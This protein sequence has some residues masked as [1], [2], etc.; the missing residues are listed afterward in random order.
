MDNA[1][2]ITFESEILI[3]F[4]F[5]VLIIP[6]SWIFAWLVAL[7]VHEFSHCIALS[8]TG[9]SIDRI[10]IGPKGILMNTEFNSH[11]SEVISSLAGPLGGI[12][13]LL[14]VRLYPKIAICS[15]FLSAYNLLPIY[16]LDGG[17][18]L[19]SI[20]SA[21]LSSQKVARTEKYLVFIVILVILFLGLYASFILKLGYL[22]LIFTGILMFKN[23]PG[24]CACKDRPLRVK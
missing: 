22:P 13:L 7:F 10:T 6:F 9:N 3:I 24:K 2:K 11:R 23:K 15:L 21:R 18:A 4:A 14:T 17:R 12:F 20:L 1:V 5:A 8:L 19:R 16:P